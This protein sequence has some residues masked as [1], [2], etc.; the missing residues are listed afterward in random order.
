[1]YFGQGE[2]KG[3]SW[4]CKCW[5]CC[6]CIEWSGESSFQGNDVLDHC[7][8]QECLSY[9]W[10]EKFEH[11][12]GLCG[13]Q[14]GFIW[15][16]AWY[17]LL[18]AGMRG[19][20]AVV[21]L[22]Q[23]LI[24]SLN[25]TVFAVFLKLLRGKCCREG[26]HCGKVIRGPQKVAHLAVFLRPP[27]LGELEMV[28]ASMWDCAVRLRTLNSRIPK[29]SD[30]VYD[31]RI[32]GLVASSDMYKHVGYNLGWVAWLTAVM[33]WTRKGWDL[34]SWEIQ[35]WLVGDDGALFGV[36]GFVDFMGEY[37]LIPA[38]RYSVHLTTRVNFHC[39]A[40]HPILFRK[41]QVGIEWNLAV[42]FMFYQEGAFLWVSGGLFTV[43]WGWCL[44]DFDA[45]LVVLVGGSFLLHLEDLLDQ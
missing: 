15:L 39:H 29:K 25:Q 11:W 13:G 34:S 3:Q 21:P 20:L 2:W 18:A 41:H 12:H 23:L 8:R 35:V 17:K 28:T 32:W 9:L 27:V 33:K 26:V 14:T 7:S 5:T 16:N 30:V 19:I 1:M 38:L 40:L 37:F 44:D 6:Q 43:S 22:M 36:P 45:V 24:G 42:R 31:S 4:C 10:F